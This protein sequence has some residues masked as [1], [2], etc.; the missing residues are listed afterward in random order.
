MEALTP[1]QRSELARKAAA[2]R[3]GK[4]TASTSEVGHGAIG[5]EIT[6]IPIDP[7]FAARLTR[8]KQFPQSIEQA[9]DLDYKDWKPTVRFALAESRPDEEILDEA[10]NG[11]FRYL[12]PGLDS[13][14]NLQIRFLQAC[15]ELNIPKTKWPHFETVVLPDPMRIRIEMPS[16]LPP[17]FDLVRDSGEAWRKRANRAW[18]EYC[19]HCLPLV[20]RQVNFLAGANNAGANGTP[21][22]FLISQKQRRKTGKTSP[23]ELR[24]KWAALHYCE[25]WS[26]GEIHASEELNPKSYGSSRIIRAVQALLE[27]LKLRMQS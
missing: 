13:H 7:D 8:M 21:V 1:A 16:F 24:L 5:E 4:P 2:A 9:K 10:K 14:G 18:S 27:E 17:P 19:A 6:P 12:H 3:W 26:Y 23:L 22:K 20:R 11:R 25:E 15:R